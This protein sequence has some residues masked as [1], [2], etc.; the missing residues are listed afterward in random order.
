M[1]KGRLS[2]RNKRKI[3]K[4]TRRRMLSRKRGGSFFT[5]LFGTTTPE[6]KNVNKVNEA[7]E[8]VDN[9]DIVALRKEVD[10]LKTM[11]T[12][13]N[14]LKLVLDRVDNLKTLLNKIESVNTSLERVKTTI[15]N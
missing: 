13:T 6:N 8:G 15:C 14:D 1:R 10:S 3:S 9:R 4:R 5:K 2:K 11:I 7:N 12:N